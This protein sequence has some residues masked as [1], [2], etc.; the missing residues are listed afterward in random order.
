MNQQVIQVLQI[1]VAILLMLSILLQNRGAGLGAS[2]GGGGEIYRTK[3]G[4]EKFLFRSTI[5]LI[6]IFM[7]LALSGLFTQK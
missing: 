5:V 6:A 4:A 1:I 7:A 3:R 2:F